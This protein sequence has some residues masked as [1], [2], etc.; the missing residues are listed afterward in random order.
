M[1]NAAHVFSPSP[2]RVAGRSQSRFWGETKRLLALFEKHREA[3]DYPNAIACFGRL[4]QFGFHDLIRRP[5][6]DR[7]KKSIVSIFQPQSGGAHLHQRMLQAGY[8]DFWWMFPNRLCQSVCYASD[9]ALQLFLRGGCTCHSHARP[10]PNILAKLDRAGVEKI[11]IHLRNP[12]E[13]AVAAYQV[14]APQTDLSSF[15]IEHIGYYV[16]W[17]VQWLRFDRASPGLVAFSYHGELADPHALLCRVFGELGAAPPAR[18][19]ATAADDRWRRPSGDDWRHG[20]TPEAQT[21]VTRRVHA[22]LKE[23]PAFDRLWS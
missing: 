9:D 14:R 22:D 23:F 20:V 17:V 10:D 6:Y 3:N 5:G 19:S 7:A 21:F 16:S 4:A 11:W 2:T 8:R 12:A 15:V 1:S 18:S 13:S